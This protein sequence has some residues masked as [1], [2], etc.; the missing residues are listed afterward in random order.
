MS[1]LAIEKRQG[2]FGGAR[3]I[4]LGLVLVVVG[5]WAI[6]LASAQAAPRPLA[7][8]LVTMVER[9]EGMVA[10]YEA[11]YEA[12]PPMERTSQQLSAPWSDAERATI[13]AAALLGTMEKTSR[14]TWQPG[15]EAYLAGLEFTLE[16]V[17]AAVY[18]AYARQAVQIADAVFVALGKPSP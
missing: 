16:E 11:A 13:A 6:W 3:G 18:F 14:D 5:L 7:P 10:A 15:Y 2:R 12:V 17:R 4:V 1:G 8:V 9:Y